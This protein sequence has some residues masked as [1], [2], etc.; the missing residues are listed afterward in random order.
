MGAGLKFSTLLSE[1]Q[2]KKFFNFF[3]YYY[4]K[5]TN[6]SIEKFFFRVIRDIKKK[7]KNIDL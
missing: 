1:S 3:L 6:F 2:R 5:I 4:F 7:Y